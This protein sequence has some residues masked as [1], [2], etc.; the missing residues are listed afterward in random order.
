MVGASRVSVAF[1]AG[2]L[3]GGSLLLACATLTTDQEQ[4]LGEDAARALREELDF[5]RDPWVVDYVDSLGGQVLRAAGPQPFDFRFHVVRDPELN[6]F[7][8]PAGYIY[9]NTGILL[10][11]ANVS[12][13]A[14]VLAHEIGH[15]ALRHVAEN[16]NRQRNTQLAY[17][18]ASVLAS[19][20]VGGYAAAG[21][22]MAGQLAAVAYLNQFSRED[23]QEAD[24]FALE[25][26]PRA[27]YDP[28]G[29]LTFFETLQARSGRSG[30]LAFL[31]S[32]PT[33][34]AR[35]EAAA[36]SIAAAPL[37]GDLQVSDRGRLQIIQRRIELLG[38]E[39]G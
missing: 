36:A 15:V 2:W 12:E 22:Q 6:A 14:G 26:L 4:D 38:Q 18:T 37:S 28:N 21:G 29:L 1:A 17:E 10:Q 33:T 35:I 23:E 34:A 31:A 19:V 16:Y 8:L 30:V 39:R 9:M 11:A 25:I 3:A 5:V 24:A 20:L 27:G 13:L 7:A 32:H